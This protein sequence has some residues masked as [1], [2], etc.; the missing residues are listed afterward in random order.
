MSKLKSSNGGHPLSN[1]SGEQKIMSEK[2]ASGL[3]ENI[4]NYGSKM[5]NFDGAKK[6]A[7]WYIDTSEKVAKNALELQ[8]TSTAWAKETPLAPIFE[9][10]QEF[11]KK[12]VERSTS[13]ARTIWRLE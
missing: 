3:F 8:K 4:S 12:L 11:S 1:K 6:L 2:Q 10:Q 7:A 9:A 13:A 5:M